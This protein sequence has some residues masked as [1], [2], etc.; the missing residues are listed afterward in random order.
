MRKNADELLIHALVDIEAIGYPHY[1]EPIGSW[2]SDKHLWEETGATGGELGA[3]SLFE[4]Y[5]Y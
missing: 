2:E 1:D 5:K 3:M 4:E